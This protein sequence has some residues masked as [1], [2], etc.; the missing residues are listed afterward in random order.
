MATGTLNEQSTQPAAGTSATGTS[1]ERYQDYIEEQLDRTS[2][3]VRLVDIAA[4]FTTLAIA[5][6]GVMLVAAVVDHWIVPGG[7]GGLGRW[8]FFLTIAVGAGY[9]IAR[10]IAPLLVRRINPLYAARAIEQSE[11]TL[12]NSLINFLLLRTAPKNVRAGVYRAV[13]TR[14]ARDLTHVSVDTAV[15]R[16]HLIKLGYV[17]VAVLVLFAAYVF[18][19]PKSPFPSIGR[20]VAPWG[21][22][23]RPSRV[24]IELYPHSPKEVFR[25]QQL[26][27]SALVHG[28]D[29]DEPVTLYWS[30]A[31]GQIVAEPVVMHREKDDPRHRCALP[32]NDDNGLRQDITYWVEAGDARTPIVSVPVLEELFITVDEIRYDFPQY[33]GKEPTTQPHGDIR[34]VERTMVTITATANQQIETAHLDYDCDG[35][36]D[37]LAAEIDGN[38]AVFRVELRLSGRERQIEQSTYWVRFFTPEGRENA[39]PVKHRIEVLP[40]WP[41][42]VNIV[43]P[44][45]ERIEVLPSGKV[46]FRLRARDNDYGLNHVGFVIDKGSKQLAQVPLLAKKDRPWLGEA[47]LE[48]SWVF[49]PAK[50]KLQPGDV[51]HVSAEVKDNRQPKEQRRRSRQKIEIVV[52]EPPVPNDAQ[53]PNRENPEQPKD[54]MGNQPDM[55]D[56][57]MQPNDQPMDK[58]QEGGEQDMGEP[59]EGGENGGEQQDGEQQPNEGGKGESGDMGEGDMS[60]QGGEKGEGSEGGKSGGEKGTDGEAKSSEGMGTGEGDPSGMGR[61]SDDPNATPSNKPSETGGEGGGAPQ[62]RPA[63]PNDDRDVIDRTLKH[64]DQHQPGGSDAKPGTGENQPG[65]SD[66]MNKTQSGDMGQN[67]DGDMS[68]GAGNKP[69]KPGDMSDPG[70]GDS[71]QPG[72]KPGDPMAGEK[73]GGA[74]EQDPMNSAGKKPMDSGDMS[75]GGTKP[76]D[77]PS[78]SPMGDD[79]AGSSGANPGK[80]EPMNSSG[81]GKKPSQGDASQESKGD[82]M[83]E[84]KNDGNVNQQKKGQGSQADDEGHGKRDGKGTAG[85]STSEDE[86]AGK[87]EQRG[88]GETSDMAGDDKAA[89]GET[90]SSDESKRGEGTR[91]DGTGDEKGGKPSDDPMGDKKPMGS[92]SKGGEPSKSAGDS[93]DGKTDKRSK[94]GDPN[95]FGGDQEGRIRRGGEDD[96]PDPTGDDPAAPDAKR[97][98]YA[99]KTTELALDHLK[100]ELAKGESDLFDKKDGLTREQ[101]QAWAERMERLLKDAQQSGAKSTA[102]KKLDQT[103]DNLGI[104]PQRSTVGRGTVR[105]QFRDVRSGTRS[106]PPADFAEQFRAY[107]KGTSQSGK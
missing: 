2:S 24:E 103:L 47:W 49:E 100:K 16:S 13:E 93:S 17:F 41:P 30:T 6:F 55:G 101:A 1:A 7:L 99:R 15:D 14:A 18:I 82:G 36:M 76:E 26:S 73:P 34:A 60:Q 107:K 50:Y 32:E 42:E 9:Y 77:N 65:D 10:F 3:Y 105:D 31:D 54:P 75:G 59:M 28:L 58:P 106:R 85:S 35:T 91:R 52:L 80:K 53:N 45:K 57:S 20:V 46:P 38:R 23:D 66:P 98:D 94:D 48:R 56:P 51:V 33:T 27:V 29:D 68:D 72:K 97:R 63:N 61:K 96:R 81:D 83:G 40:D 104:R 39:K 11:P 95:G 44:Q 37:E 70:T 92:D 71:Q 87:S 74:G 43:E 8:I 21:E 78:G 12:K 25:G 62:Q 64:R 89:Q 22:I 67:K 5:A 19:S 79:K 88:M 90:G 84:Q 4:A 86:G 69:G 102:K